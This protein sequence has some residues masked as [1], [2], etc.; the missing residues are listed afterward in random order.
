VSGT[1]QGY[2]QPLCTNRGLGTQT[3]ISVDPDV[4]NMNFSIYHCRCQCWMLTFGLDLATLVESEV[5]RE[6]IRLVGVCSRHDGRE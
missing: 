5:G 2:Y 4:C 6:E 3:A 1:D